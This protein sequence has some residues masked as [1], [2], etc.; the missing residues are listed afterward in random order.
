MRLLF[1]LGDRTGALRQYD[2]CRFALQQELGVEP[3]Q[4]TQILAEQIRHDK[5]DMP[6]IDQTSPQGAAGENPSSLNELLSCL[7]NFNHTLNSIQSQLHTQIQEIEHL[8]KN[9]Q[10]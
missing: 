7:N 4:Q 5:L 6:L 2:H 10:E 3:C 8:M 9:K 1:L